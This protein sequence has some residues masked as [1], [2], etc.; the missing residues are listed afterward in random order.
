MSN[1]N[2]KHDSFNNMH[3]TVEENLNYLKFLVENLEEIE[4]NSQRVAKYFFKRM[5]K[6]V[7]TSRNNEHC[8]SH[9]QKMLK[10]HKNVT[11]IILFLQEKLNNYN[12]NQLNKGQNFLNSS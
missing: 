7:G 3:W 4:Q 5:E 2:L 9:H 1:S 6:S 10:R 8:R 11:N 12:N